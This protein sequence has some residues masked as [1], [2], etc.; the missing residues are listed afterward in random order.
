M[1]DKTFLGTKWENGVMMLMEAFD[2]TIFEFSKVYQNA[3]D[4]LCKQYGKYGR[5]S[6][7]FMHRVGPR[8]RSVFHAPFFNQ[9]LLE[10]F[11]NNTAPLKKLFIGPDSVTARY[12]AIRN[13]CYEDGIGIDFFELVTYNPVGK[14][15]IPQFFKISDEVKS[16]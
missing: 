5:Y 11:P 4:T 15:V 12:D 10:R 2:S 13:M 6:K 16:D 9:Y 3:C 8:L 1:F 14:D 7:E